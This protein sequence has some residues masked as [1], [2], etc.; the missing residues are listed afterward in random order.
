MKWHNREKKIRKRRS[1][2]E[3]GKPFRRERPKDSS[4]EKQLSKYFKQLRQAE[5]RAEEDDDDDELY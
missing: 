3:M 1:T 2:K 4:S 5:K